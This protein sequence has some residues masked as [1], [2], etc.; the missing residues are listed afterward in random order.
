[1]ERYV[2]EIDVLNALWWDED[3]QVWEMTDERLEEL[4]RR[5]VEAEL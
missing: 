4:S 2:K 3:N 5:A 1:M